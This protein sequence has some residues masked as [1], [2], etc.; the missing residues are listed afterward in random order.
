MFD[1]AGLPMHEIA[2]TNDLAPEGLPDSLVPETHSQN[3]HSASHAPNEF[4]ADACFARRTRTGRDH[5]PLRPHLFDVA[6]RNL[7][8]PPH[9]DLGTQFSEILHQVVGERIV[10]VEDENHKNGSYINRS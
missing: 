3:P 1:L 6:E 7:I 2:S 5:E 9:L 10:V 8:I 4:N